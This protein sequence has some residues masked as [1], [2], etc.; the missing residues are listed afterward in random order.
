MNGY[1]LG[2]IVKNAILD[3]I[4][5]KISSYNGLLDD[6]DEKPTDP[7][8]L[9]SEDDRFVAQRLDQLCSFHDKVQKLWS[10][11]LLKLLLK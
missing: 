1:W 2:K 10:S 8:L 7:E 6:L 11:P 9:V 3:T 4:G 5:R